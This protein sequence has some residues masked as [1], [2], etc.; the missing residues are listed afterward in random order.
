MSISMSDLVRAIWS[1]GIDL[2]M[3]WFRMCIV[4]VVRGRFKAFRM[5]WKCWPWLCRNWKLRSIFVTL[6]KL[7]LRE[8]W[9]RMYAKWRRKGIK[10]GRSNK[11]SKMIK[12]T[13]SKSPLKPNM[14]SSKSVKKSRTWKKIYRDWK[15]EIAR[16]A[17]AVVWSSISCKN[18]R[19]SRSQ[20]LQQC[21]RPSNRSVHCSTRWYPN[22]LKKPQH[23]LTNKPSTQ[24]QWQASHQD[25]WKS[26]KDAHPQWKTIP[27][28]AQT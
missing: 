21:S 2:R 22:Q 1:R 6:N 26:S 7:H 16:N 15:T 13:L 9:A 14:D 4:V 28:R 8:N 10:Y 20:P 19:E 3:L 18:S 11:F 12:T 5:V 17:W 25:K 27:A 23:F 24:Q